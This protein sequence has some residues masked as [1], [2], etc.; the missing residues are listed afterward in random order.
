VDVNKNKLNYKTKQMEQTK[1]TL[2]GAVNK[3]SL[4]LVDWEKMTG[5]EDLV[6]IF[7]SMGLSFSGHHPHFDTIKHLL[8]LNN[9]ITPNQTP[10]QP[11]K[12][13]LR[14]PKLKQL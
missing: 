8:D 9:P 14:L 6:L 4:Y 12:E 3:D 13:D 10:P 5:V 11:K 2:E 7:A 1:I